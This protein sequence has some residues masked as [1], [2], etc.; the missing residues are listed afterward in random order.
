MGVPFSH[1]VQKASE[2]IDNIAPTIVTTLRNIDTTVPYV[3]FALVANILVSII[4]TILIVTLL[5]AVIALLITVNPDLA[6]E[7]KRLV[8]PVLRAWLNVP[9]M[10]VRN[11]PATVQHQP[12]NEKRGGRCQTGILE[13]RTN[14]EDKGVH[15]QVRRPGKGSLLVSR[16][17]VAQVSFQQVPKPE[18]TSALAT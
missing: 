12:G 3:K 13:D 10:L 9:S 7:R 17:T 5:I 2:Y 4:L 6:E 18:P 8:T 14:I 16:S 15:L 1:E 11:S